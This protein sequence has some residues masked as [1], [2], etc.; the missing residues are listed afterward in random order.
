MNTTERGDS[1]E[2][3]L[4]V[5][6]ISTSPSVSQPHTTSESEPTSQLN[7]NDALRITLRISH[8]FAPSEFVDFAPTVPDEIRPKPYF[9]TLLFRHILLQI[10]GTL[11]SDLPPPESFLNGRTWEVDFV[12]DQVE[13]PT[14]PLCGDEQN[15]PTLE[16]LSSFGESLKGKRVTL[17]ASVKGSFA[18][19]LTSY[20]TALGMD[21]TPVS[22]GGEV[23]GSADDS[24]CL[25]QHSIASINP[26]PSSARTEPLSG[27]PEF[28]F[29][30]DDVDVLK[31]RLHVLRSSN[32]SNSFNVTP[33]KK[34]SLQ[35]NHR[36]R[37]SQQVTRVLNNLRTPTAVVILHFTSLS[38]YKLVKDAV[39]SIL[40]SYLAMLIP[41]PE[42]M[43]I[44][45][46]AG[47][48][49][50]LIALHTA[51]MKPTVDP[52]F[53]PIATS[54][55][56]LGGFPPQIGSSPSIAPTS[57]ENATNQANI[58]A[59]PGNSAITPS[60]TQL[61]LGKATTRPLGPRTNSDRSIKSL[62]GPG[63]M[64]TSV[65]P[66]SPLALP[67]NVEYF[68][69]NA[70]KLGNSPSS[71]VVIQSPDGQTTGIY[72]HPR[73]KS[74]SRNPSSNSIEREKA[75]LPTPSRSQSTSRM[76]TNP[77]KESAV[78]FSSLYGVPSKTTYTPQP[79]PSEAAIPDI[80]T[81]SPSTPSDPPLVPA[82]IITTPLDS[83][84]LKPT[85]PSP[86]SA[87]SPSRRTSVESRRSPAVGHGELSSSSPSKRSSSRK[88]SNA[89]V[90]DSKDT[91]SSLP[92]KQK[93]KMATTGDANVVPPISVLIVDGMCQFSSLCDSLI[94]ISADNPINQTIL[95]TFMR[96]K[97]IKYDLASNGQEAVQKWRSGGF[98]LILV[99]NLVYFTFSASSQSL[100]WISKCHSW[101]EFKLRKR[102]VD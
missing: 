68:S 83:Q 53:I 91:A 94:R 11:R 6:P 22:L 25:M 97:K 24:A 59:T 18:H 76:V 100:R 75:Q 88:P 71:G 56:T 79:T 85:T 72:F 61:S 82:K 90:M 28:I 26:T 69:A 67:D 2:L 62:E 78:T 19:H 52:F 43:V 99:R 84:Q 49:R 46:P 44:P 92:S 29:I 96:R 16:Q 41:L 31:D 9:S 98:H 33:R 54:P 32:P 57:N 63:G 10:G 35:A 12:L 34:P 30:D 36:P 20:L 74:T 80:Q 55:T 101:M 37:S 15:Q 39:Q 70:Q 14:T 65:L 38:N 66:P 50:F 3:G 42:I 21:V 40:A 86:S 1:I 95:S 45:K 4:L 51:V 58:S 27:S 81:S 17:Y 102:F 87:R 64:A 60:Q 13:A 47:P 23:D 77:N 48:R 89:D 8:R 5:S 73:G 7:Q 93:G